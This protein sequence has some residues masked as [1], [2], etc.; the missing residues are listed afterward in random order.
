MTYTTDRTINQL[1]NGTTVG[2]ADEFV[3]FQNGATVKTSANALA[4]YIASGVPNPPALP[5]FCVCNLTGT[6]NPSATGQAI[7]WN[8]STGPQASL[9]NISNPTRITVPSGTTYVRLI[10]CAVANLSSFTG[11]IA[12]G[13]QQN[14]ANYQNLAGASTRRIA[15]SSVPGWPQFSSVPIACVG[16]DYFE[17][18]FFYST[19]SAIPIPAS[20]ATYF[21]ME[22]LN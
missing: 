21:C 16:G 13:T 9:W 1:A 5:P 22:L 4:T 17:M 12:V 7:S 20:N 19:G 14:G 2:S 18:R 10:G 8:T 6:F 15:G 11:E 3:L